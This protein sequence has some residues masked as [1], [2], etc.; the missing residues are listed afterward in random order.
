MS[1]SNPRAQRA[2]SAEAKRRRAKPRELTEKEASQVIAGTSS[3]TTSSEDANRIEG[4]P[5]KPIILGRVFNST[6]SGS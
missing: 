5:D 3:R 2:A 1:R 6:G 4:D